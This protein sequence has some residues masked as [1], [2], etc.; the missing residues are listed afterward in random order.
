MAALR[1]APEQESPDEGLIGDGGNAVRILTVHGAKGLE[2]PIVWLLDAN[3]APRGDGGYRVL[4]DWPPQ[5]PAPQHRT[6]TPSRACWPG[7]WR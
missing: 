7:R 1:R 4:L 2:A 5:A 6:A 3:T